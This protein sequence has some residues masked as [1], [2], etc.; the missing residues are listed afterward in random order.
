MDLLIFICSIGIKVLAFK[1]TSA[2]SGVEKSLHWQNDSQS[3]VLMTEKYVGRSFYA[4]ITFD[5]PFV[6]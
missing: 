2:Q 5:K 4:T 1:Y 3:H 6:A